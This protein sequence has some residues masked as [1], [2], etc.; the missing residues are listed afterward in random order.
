MLCIALPQLLYKTPRRSQ[1]KLLPYKDTG[2]I[3]PHIYTSLVAATELSSK[4]WRPLLSV[5]L[6][7]YNQASY[8]SQAILS[9]LAE[10]KYPLELIVVDDGSTDDTA[11]L[12]K[13]FTEDKRVRII[14]QENAG[15]STALNVG[16]KAACGSFLSWTSSDNILLTR[17]IPTL[18]DFL[19][20]NPLIDFGFANV[21][22]IDENARPYRHSSYRK[23]DQSPEDSSVLL[24]PH[25]SDVL[26]ERSDNFINACFIYRRKLR[27]LVGTH[28][29]EYRGFED[30]D[31]W[32]RCGLQGRIAHTVSR[33]P[34]YQYRLHSSSLTE[35]IS[36]SELQDLQKPLV[37]N[38]RKLK[39]LLSEPLQLRIN[40]KS[41][42]HE[43]SGFALA[44]CLSASGQHIE[45]VEVASGE[46]SRNTVLEL[47]LADPVVPKW[48][49]IGPSILE[50]IERKRL[51]FESLTHLNS[52]HLG[53][54]NASCPILHCSH[55]AY[56]NPSYTIPLVSYLD[57]GVN[58]NSVPGNMLVLPPITIPTVFKRARDSNFAAVARNRKSQQ[59][60]ILVFPPDLH[61]SESELSKTQQASIHWCK[62]QL[63]DLLDTQ[64]QPLFIL[65]CETAQ[66]REFADQLN[67]SISDNSN[68]RII[69]IRHEASRGPSARNESLMYVLSSVDSILSLKGPIQD[70]STLQELRLEACLAAAAGIS[71]VLLT[72]SLPDLQHLGPYD[73]L[74]T[75]TP[76]SKRAE[77]L[78]SLIAT[79]VLNAPHL[80][81]IVL[82]DHG[83]L[84]GKKVIKTIADF[85]SAS[86]ERPNISSLEQYLLSQGP[87]EL[88]DRLVRLLVAG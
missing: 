61:T 40:C 87:A 44:Q 23:E 27:D 71:I 18:V 17:A 80:S 64:K 85:L 83:D 79:E 1:S 84:M 58:Q 32:L 41:A 34:L 4:T 56:L 67:L 15:L 6:P 59:S 39:E 53:H 86:A 60:I 57:E 74:D 3:K 29:P 55:L 77:L 51:C 14:S 81:A 8:L 28:R 72:E 75:T 82:K 5:V 21:A 20:A 76:V 30:Y 49:N 73:L 54:P 43:A 7:T 25:T 22:L 12:L 42:D 13:S 26:Y 88:G 31:Y 62:K 66:Q 10:E 35:E 47:K 69:D 19:I 45:S 63:I 16:F 9:V 2:P 50:S 68:L 70:S 11:Q 37:T 24:L 65:F 48:K 52:G 46:F 33:K 36:C 78:T 38:A